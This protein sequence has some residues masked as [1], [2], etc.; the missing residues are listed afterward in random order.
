MDHIRMAGEPT[1]VPAPGHALMASSSLLSEAPTTPPSIGSPHSDTTWTFPN[2]EIGWLL[3]LSS[4]LELTGQITPVEAW[5][6]MCHRCGSRGI[7]H[8]AFQEA[9]VELAKKSHCEGYEC[10]AVLMITPRAYH[11]RL[12]IW[13]GAG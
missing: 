6:R 10:C 13:C 5:N 4:R 9:G 7:S 1:Y 2:E 11:N 3:E 12:Q 8:R